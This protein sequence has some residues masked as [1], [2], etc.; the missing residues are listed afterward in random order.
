VSVSWVEGA[1]DAW[2][3]AD[4]SAAW[5][6]RPDADVYIAGFEAGAEVRRAHVLQRRDR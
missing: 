2:N 5:L 4:M 1:E 3:E 6:A